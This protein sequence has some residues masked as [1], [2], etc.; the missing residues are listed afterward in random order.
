V[1]W[2]P[3][4]LFGIVLRSRE[5]VAVARWGRLG[6]LE[7]CDIVQVLRYILLQIKQ[8]RLRYAAAK[9]LIY[10]QALR[11]ERPV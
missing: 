9:L 6:R 10:L 11:Q 2:Y 7:A 1:G 3:R 5:G 8:H 4:G